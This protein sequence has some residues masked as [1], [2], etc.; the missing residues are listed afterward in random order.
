MSLDPAPF[1]M[2][3]FEEASPAIQKEVKSIMAKADKTCKKHDGVKAQYD[4]F[5]NILLLR[6]GTS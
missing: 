3:K 1:C 2:K 4:H 5:F 6:R